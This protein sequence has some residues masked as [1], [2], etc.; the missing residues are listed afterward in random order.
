VIDVA[1]RQAYALAVQHAVQR[2]VS[3][4]E[5]IFAALAEG[6]VIRYTAE[7]LVALASRAEH[8]AGEGELSEVLEAEP[9]DP[10]LAE[11]LVAVE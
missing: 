11:E 4:V 2:D 5:F 1:E 7:E 10:S 9:D 6:G 3:T 8:A